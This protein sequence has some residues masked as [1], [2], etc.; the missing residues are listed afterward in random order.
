MIR[1]DVFAMI[2]IIMVGYYVYKTVTDL[3]KLKAKQKA[4]MDDL[5]LRVSKMEELEE[6]IQVLEKIVTDKNY[7]LKDEIDSLK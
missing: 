3:A 2:A 5:D 1:I 7:D 6:R 4:E